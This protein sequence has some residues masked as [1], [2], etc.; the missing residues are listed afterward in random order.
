MTELWSLG[1]HQ[2]REQIPKKNQRENCGERE[3]QPE[4]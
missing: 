4:K 1:E 3:A 2:L